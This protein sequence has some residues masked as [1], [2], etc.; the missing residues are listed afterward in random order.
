MATTQR[1]RGSAQT[2]GGKAPA[3]LLSRVNLALYGFQTVDGFLLV[4]TDPNL[5]I[6]A[7]GQTDTTE[8][9]VY[10]MSVNN[11]VREP[12]CDGTL[13]ITKG[14]MIYIT[15]GTAHGNTLWWLSYP[16]IGTDTRW[17]PGVSS[18]TLIKWPDNH[19]SGTPLE[20]AMISG[21]DVF[22]TNLAVSEIYTYA[23]ATVQPGTALTE[24]RA[25][26]GT[27][28]NDVF[29]VLGAGSAQAVDSVVTSLVYT[30]KTAV[31]NFGGNL[32]SAR[33]N[34]AAAGN[35]TL[36]IF[37]GG[38]PVYSAVTDRYV[39]ATNAVSAGTVLGSARGQ[40]AACTS[41][42][43]AMFFAGAGGAGITPDRYVDKYNYSTDA[44]VRGTDLARVNRFRHVAI[45]NG[46]AAW[47]V[48]GYAL[49][50]LTSGQVGETYTFVNDTT[51]VASVATA[52]RKERAAS[53]SGATLGLI[54]GGYTTSGA[55]ELATTEQVSLLVFT[56]LPSTSLT[57]ARASPASFFYNG[58]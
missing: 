40:F 46:S 17:S 49:G 19:L 58:I 54:A 36:G 2:I 25:D 44:V 37:G 39:Y 10:K 57:T 31:F 23:S 38:D 55:V 7:A 26:G 6:V 22:I 21:G 29:G 56:A 15:D 5:R 45:S 18:L 8:N 3:H 30:Y 35:Y 24:T 42:A 16:S 43:N 48:S 13:D 33:E 34:L 4:D 32:T 14:T 50:T 41:G 51:V 1:L 47:I 53:A 20:Y 11:W 27:C 9:G 12:D 28:G 52:S